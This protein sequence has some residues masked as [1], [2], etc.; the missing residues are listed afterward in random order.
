MY[1]L[2]VHVH[3]LCTCICIMYMLYVHVHVLCTMYMY[4]VHVHI[5][6]EALS[7]QQYCHYASGIECGQVL[8]NT[9]YADKL[10]Q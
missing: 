3:V 10:I 4:Y 9:N 7:A 2:Y 1:M 5:T 6:N 8:N